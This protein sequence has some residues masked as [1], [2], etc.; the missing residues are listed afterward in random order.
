MKTLL[1]RLFW[2]LTKLLRSNGSDRE[3]L[4]YFSDSHVFCYGPFRAYSACRDQDQ[5]ALTI[6]FWDSCNIWWDYDPCLGYM[7]VG[8]H[9]P[10][11]AEI[12]YDLYKLRLN[13]NPKYLWVRYKY[14]IFGLK[15]ANF[16]NILQDLGFD[17]YQASTIYHNHID[18]YGWFA[19]L[20]L[21][22][23][24][25]VKKVITPDDVLTYHLFCRN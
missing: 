10:T 15:R 23:L 19:R 5:Y 21:R 16:L 2:Y 4:H 17:W 12:W 11:R 7:T 22:Y 14:R 24:L 1:V 3:D 18:K 25:T 13:L 9:V 8:M 6:H 20:Y